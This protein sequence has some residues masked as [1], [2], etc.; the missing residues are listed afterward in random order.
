MLCDDP[1]VEGQDGRGIVWYSVVRPGCE[2]ELSHLQRV[3]VAASELGGM[4]EYSGYSHIKEF[5]H[6]SLH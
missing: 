3:F 4:R 5:Q 2:V 6:P 1:P